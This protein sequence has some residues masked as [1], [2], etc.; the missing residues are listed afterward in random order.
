MY[1]KIINPKT[2]R[3]VNIT[4]K[5]GKAILN[6]YLYTL[7]ANK[8][9]ASKI[10]GSGAQNISLNS[11]KNKLGKKLG[12][13]GY[14]TAYTIK[15]DEDLWGE[16][17]EFSGSFTKKDCDGSII[18]MTKENNKDFYRETELQAKLKHPKIWKYG[19]CKDVIDKYKLEEKLDE[20]LFD[21]LIYNADK[22]ISILDNKELLHNFKINFKNLLLKIK[23]LHDMNIGHFDI[24]LENIM[25][26]YKQGNKQFEKLV[27]IDYGF[28]TESPLSKIKGSPGYIDPGVILNNYLTLKSDIWSLGIVIFTCM[29]NET[30]PFYFPIKKPYNFIHELKK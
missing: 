12:T 10:G 13:G 28:A 21:W 17:G 26:K 8:I 22:H 15:C 19:Q 9:G 23:Q 25:I 7:N 27:L 3:M 5:L 29:F 1:S 4:S 14:K 20:E 16:E 11:C 30:G 24:K 2:N 18:L 6:K